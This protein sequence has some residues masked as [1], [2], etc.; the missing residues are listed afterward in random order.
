MYTPHGARSL[1]DADEELGK[2]GDTYRL[3][4]LCRRH[5]SSS[6][7]LLPC[8][9]VTPKSFALEAVLIGKWFRALVISYKVTSS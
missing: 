1:T 8:T 2:G 5:G 3:S 4:Y 6:S 9:S 7:T